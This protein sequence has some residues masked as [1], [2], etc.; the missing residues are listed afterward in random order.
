M[1]LVVTAGIAAFGSVLFWR[2]QLL[3]GSDYVEFPQHGQTV[4]KARAAE[5][6]LFP[7]TKALKESE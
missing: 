1:Y 3:V 6:K 5:T 7:I 4:K 2:A